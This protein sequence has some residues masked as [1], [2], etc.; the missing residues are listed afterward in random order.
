MMKLICI[1]DGV[2][3]NVWKLWSVF[4]FQEKIYCRKVKKT[5]T[6]MKV[7]TRWST[8]V[9]IRISEIIQNTKEINI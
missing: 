1:W 8:Q 5:T 2:H 6:E 9:Y 3:T 7:I 4:Q